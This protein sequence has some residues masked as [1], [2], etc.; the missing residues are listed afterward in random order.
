[1]QIPAIK[2]IKKNLDSLGFIW[3]LVKIDKRWRVN[4]SRLL[5]IADKHQHH[6]VL[7]E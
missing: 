6:R 2:K 5:N 3:Y 7:F 1:M 4:F